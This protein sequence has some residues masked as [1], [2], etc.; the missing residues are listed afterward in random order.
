MLDK[1]KIIDGIGMLEVF[2]GE[3][4]GSVIATYFEDNLPIDQPQAPTSLPWSDWSVEKTDKILET[5]V[6]Y[7]L[8]QADCDYV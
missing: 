5:I 3:C 6:E 8:Q 2:D 7:I 1:Q 4:L